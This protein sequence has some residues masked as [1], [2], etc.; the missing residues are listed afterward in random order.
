MTANICGQLFF[1]SPRYIQIR[2]HQWQFWEKEREITP[3]IGKMIF[4]AF[5]MEGRWKEKKGENVSCF[6]ANANYVLST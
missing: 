2:T 1:C 6:Y 4:K 5:L 3:K